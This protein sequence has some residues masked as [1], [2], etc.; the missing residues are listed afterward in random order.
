MGNLFTV[1]YSFQSEDP[2]ATDA[3]EEEEPTGPG[4]SADEPISMIQ[5]PARPKI[6]QE[7]WFE[8][9]LNVL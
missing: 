9:L 2:V 8:N 1:N 7:K 5:L 4:S 6:P 3:I